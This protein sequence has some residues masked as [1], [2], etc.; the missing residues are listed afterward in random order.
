MMTAKEARK[1]TFENQEGG[2]RNLEFINEQIAKAALS[3]NFSCLV[4]K[5]YFNNKII[6]ELEEYC[7]YHTTPTENDYILISW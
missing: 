6:E 3:G 1:I 2:K 5:S 4:K 7:E